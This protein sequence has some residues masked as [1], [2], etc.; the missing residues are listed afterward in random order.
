MEVTLA[1]D[2]VPLE[3]RGAL[4]PLIRMATVTLIQICRQCIG[5]CIHILDKRPNLIATVIRY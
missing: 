2:I 3:H 5:K 1:Q 4:C